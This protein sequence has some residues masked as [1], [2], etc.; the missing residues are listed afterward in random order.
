MMYKNV[1]GILWMFHPV[2]RGCF[3]AG[4][5]DQLQV[6][7]PLV[8]RPQMVIYLRRAADPVLGARRGY[9]R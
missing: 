7:Y 5:E 9:V 6:T 3:L 8:E 2:C 1:G 4:E